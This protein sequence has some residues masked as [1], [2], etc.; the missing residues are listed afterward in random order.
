LRSLLLDVNVAL[1]VLL[2]RKPHAESAAALWS[3][4]ERGQATGFLPAHGVTTVHYLATRARG[5]RFAR[6]VVEDLL[7][8]FQ[9]FAVDETVLRRALTL[10]LPDFE[11]AVCAACAA[12][13]RCE[14]IVTRDPVGFRNAPVPVLD[15]AS[16]LAWLTSSA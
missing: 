16:A 14:V 7:S 4:I 13:S 3:A 10:S 9:I 6:R 12:A 1:D 2:D 8:V 11:D 15:P 5:T